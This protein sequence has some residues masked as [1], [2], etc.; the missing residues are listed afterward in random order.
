MNFTFYATSVPIYL[1]FVDFLKS[2]NLKYSYRFIDGYIA[3][4]A[5]SCS[6]HQIDLLFNFKSE[7]KL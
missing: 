6:N 1:E 3:I 4:T 5:L 2:N 7:N